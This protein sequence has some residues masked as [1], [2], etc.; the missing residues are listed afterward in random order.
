M[1][2]TP[3]VLATL[4]LLASTLVGPTGA[5]AQRARPTE[6]IVLVVEVLERDPTPLIA[7]GILGAQPRDVTARVVAVERGAFEG[8]R[9]LLSWPMCEFSAV[10]VGARYRVHLRRFTDAPVR[11]DM[12][13]RV[14]RSAP[15]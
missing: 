2:K 8:E 15:G 9:V 13:Y 6:E 5:S 14:R 4:G 7:C 12:R 11:A 3:F 10:E 1:Q